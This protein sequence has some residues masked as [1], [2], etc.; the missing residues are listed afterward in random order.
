M[1]VHDAV[2]SISARLRKGM[3]INKAYGANSSRKAVH[4]VRGTILRIGHARRPAGYAVATRG[5]GP[6]HGVAHRVVDCVRHKHVA[7]L[8]HRHIEGLTASRW[9]A[10]RRG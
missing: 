5:P 3:L 9:H 2:V 4:I 10:A 6:P 1:A 7:A 8:P